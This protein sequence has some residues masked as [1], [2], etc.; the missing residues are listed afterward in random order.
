VKQEDRKQTTVEAHRA[1][2]VRN[3]DAVIHAL[4]CEKCALAAQGALALR[5]VGWT[6]GDFYRAVGDALLEELN[7]A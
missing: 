6:V 7:R 5:L 4:E 3:A 2:V 1:L